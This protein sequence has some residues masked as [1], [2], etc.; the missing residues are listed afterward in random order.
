MM[1]AS[2]SP[3]AAAH[4]D[5]VRVRARQWIESPVLDALVRALGG[6]PGATIDDLLAWTTQTFDTRA[7]G[8]RRDA[9]P[10]SWSSEIVDALVQAAGP[11]GL[12]ATAGPELPAYDGV[13]VLGG[14]TTGNEL[15]TALVKDLVDGGLRIGEICGLAAHR[16]FS[17]SERDEVLVQ[18]GVDTEWKHLLRCLDAA[19][20]PL[21]AEGAR[22]GGVGAQA[23]LDH[24]YRGAGGQALRL[25]VAPSASSSRAN[26]SDAVA[27]FLERHSDDPPQTLL[28]VT[29]AIYVPYQFFAV[30]ARLTAGG[31]SHVEFVGTPTGISGDGRILAQRIGQEI[32][33]AVASAVE[34]LSP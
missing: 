25:V 19:F 12:L 21:E 2:N 31:I 29:S 27:F 1:V 4:L 33:G 26:T 3:W 13:L 23:W 9:E 11:L 14:A 18:G 16:A 17:P 22:A 24:R 6:P 15:R 30:A 5:D 8:E 34:L 32:H 20:G 28:V 10:V 7:G